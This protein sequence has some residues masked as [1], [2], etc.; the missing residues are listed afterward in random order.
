[1]PP[2][3]TAHRLRGNG[4]LG[5]F[6]LGDFLLVELEA[7][8][9]NWRAAW[10]RAVREAATRPLDVRIVASGPDEV[11]EVVAGVAADAHRII[12]LSVFS[13]TSH[14]T[15][16]ELCDA[17]E[18]AAADAGVTAELVGGA[19]SH[20]TELNRGH[21]RLPSDLTALTFSSSPQMHAREQAQLIESIPMQ[22]LTA[23]DAVRIGNGR[24]VHIG[25]VTLRPRF[26]AVAT[27]PPFAEGTELDDGYAAQHVPGAT[28]PRQGSV[29]TAAWLVSAVS[30][31]SIAG[32]ASLALFET[33]GERGLVDASGR[34]TPADAAFRAIARLSGRP[35]LVPVGAL[36]RHV[37]VLAARGD[38]DQAEV[39]LANLT[40]DAVALTV[41][42]GEAAVD[43]AIAPFGFAELSV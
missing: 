8:Q 2:R 22:T 12:R 13:R 23:R 4:P 20:F 29:A 40:V 11:R 9:A 38:A 1:L 33:S 24:P 41:R 30:A 5:D 26:N 3:D 27:T 35:A 7:D 32:V 43:I 14:L 39:L 17:L 21:H 25:P 6:L 18:L 10:A 31:F 16:P 37:H 42:V 15:E 34:P 19:R 28:D 36:P